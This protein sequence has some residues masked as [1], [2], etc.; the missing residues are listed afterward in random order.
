MTLQLQN[1]CIYHIELGVL[2]NQMF[3]VLFSLQPVKIRLREELLFEK[4]LCHSK[5][6][7]ATD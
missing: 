5:N 6:A 7:A 4:L 1:M 2:L 3:R